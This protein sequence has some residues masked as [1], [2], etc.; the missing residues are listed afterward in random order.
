MNL[1][2]PKSKNNPFFNLAGRRELQE[3]EHFR[4]ESFLFRTVAA[5]I[6]IKG[7]G[8]KFP[9]QDI[10]DLTYKSFIYY[11]MVIAPCPEDDPSDREVRYSFSHLEKTDT[12]RTA[13][14][15]IDIKKLAY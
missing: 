15:K 12:R 14:I 4:F 9:V 3:E 8:R 2:K 5:C 10:R 7:G 6:V 1:L 11:K 13:K